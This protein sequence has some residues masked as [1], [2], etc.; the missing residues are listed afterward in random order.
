[1]SAALA[2]GSARRAAATGGEDIWDPPD[3]LPTPAPSYPITPGG[4][5]LPLRVLLSTRATNPQ[6]VDANAFSLDGK[7]YR[8]R[9]SIVTL[10]NGARGVVSTLSVDEY[11]YGVV[12]L[13]ISPGWPAAMLAAQAIIA[14]TYA[15]ARRSLVRQYDVVAGESDQLYGDRSVERPATTAAVDATSGQTVVFGGGVASVYYMACCGG[16]TEDAAELWGHNALPYLRG[17]ADPYCAG[18]P[19]YRW[20]ARFLPAQFARALG[21]LVGSIG[22]IQSANAIEIDPS[23]RPRAI[24][25]RGSSGSATVPVGDLRRVL[26]TSALP[27]TFITTIELSSGEGVVIEGAGRGHGVGLCQWG[28]RVMALQGADPATIVRFYFPGTSIARA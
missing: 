12:P 5:S 9:P 13:E 18:T 8:G 24:A 11:L 10:A 7:L 2:L 25:V 22:A 17:V 23:G 4:L 21:P 19:D 1:M 16:H 14:R 28:A 6:P 15:V 26:G 20:H 27:S 3:F